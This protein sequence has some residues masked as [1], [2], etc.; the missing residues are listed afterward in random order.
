MALGFLRVGLGAE[1]AVLALCTG[2]KAL[3]GDSKGSLLNVKLET[4][5]SGGR[6]KATKA[7]VTSFLGCHR[8]QKSSTKGPSKNSPTTVHLSPTPWASGTQELWESPTPTSGPRGALPTYA[9]CGSTVAGPSWALQARGRCAAHR[10]GLQG[11]PPG[12]AAL[13]VLFQAGAHCSEH[14]PRAGGLQAEGAGLLAA[15]VERPGKPCSRPCRGLGAA[16]EMSLSKKTAPVLAPHHVILQSD[17]TVATVLTAQTTQAGAPRN[18]YLGAHL[19]WKELRRRASGLYNSTRWGTRAGAQTQ[20]QVYLP[21][22][23]ALDSTIPPCC[24]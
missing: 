8:M 3:A 1:A 17:V 10:P 4:P 6:C 24:T 13:Q 11:G 5:C 23:H 7:E 12:C 14:G 22:V 15:A 9:S 18:P 2:A 20:S 21:P 19:P 16:G